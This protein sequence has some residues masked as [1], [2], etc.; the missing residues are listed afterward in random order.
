MNL[1]P[2]ISIH[3][4]QVRIALLS[5]VLSGAVLLAFGVWTWSTVQRTSL[6]RI[7]ESIRDLGERHLTVPQG[8]NHWDRV[9]ES[10]E[11][12][13]R[14][15]YILLV[16]GRDGGTV[17][18]TGNWPEALEPRQFPSPVEAGF[19][20]PPVVRN[21][22][23]GSGPRPGSVRPEAPAPFPPSG[24]IP[25]R[26]G[27]PFRPEPPRGPGAER[28]SPPRPM[29]IRAQPFFSYENDGR[30]WR[31]GVMSNPE[32]TLALGLDLAPYTS[33]MDRL[34]RLFL[35][36][37]PC[38]LFVI[39]L[40]GWW[41]ARRALR[42]V[43]AL[44]RTAE[45]ITAKGLD[46]RIPLGEEDVEFERLIRVFNGML[47]RLEKSFQQT[48]RF[49]ADAAHELKTPLTILQGELSQA[50]QQADPGSDRQE[51]LGRLLD[52]VQRLKSITR[53]LLLLS[54][55]DAGQLRPHLEPTHLSELIQA[56][57]DDI[58]TLAPGL[59]VQADIPPGIWVEADPDLFRQVIQNLIGNAVK[60][61]VPD[62]EVR[63]RLGVK[64]PRVWFSIE[65]TGPGIPEGDRAHIFERFY[66]A[67]KA[68]NRR[69]DGVGL[70]LSLS[71]EIVRAH[72]GD[73][74]LD[75]ASAGRTRFTVTLPA[76]ASRAPTH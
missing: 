50:V 73:L 13:T 11:F 8:P 32:I 60:Y 48:A 22:V 44:T 33:E 71:R 19:A 9:R 58:E 24:N 5:T 29:P 55:A 63:L 2:P 62:G 26:P 75:N 56:A 27:D 59:R 4:F 66:R 46:R 43:E 67:D 69:V 37:A 36:A 39:G 18:R 53:K 28:V 15:P 38:A 10:L 47:D 21:P 65:N 64:E 76:T 54:L 16:R 49:S 7:D 25:G 68:R 6:R 14:T 42:P 17:F 51:V 41:L 23:P 40:S 72:H 35:L 45:G 57:K 1:R 74:V 70:G 52:E 20:Q 61:N 30:R 3:S 34:R 31:I 12:V